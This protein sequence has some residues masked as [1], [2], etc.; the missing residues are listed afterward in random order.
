[1]LSRSKTRSREYRP[2][3][4]PARVAFGSIVFLLSLILCLGLTSSMSPSSTDASWQDATHS[5]GNFNAATVTA[6]VI[7]QCLVRGAL[8]NVRT[9]IVWYIPGEAP[10]SERLAQTEI[11]VE[12]EGALGGLV[13]L[14]LSEDDHDTS[15]GSSRYTTTVP[16][17]LLEG[18]LLGT[19]TIDFANQVEGWTSTSASVRTN[20]GIGGLL[21]NCSVQ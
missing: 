8:V 9:E 7:E 3:N 19:A 11:H 18:L 13:R 1:M 21:G 17:S 2:D 16:A 20:A 14:R 5:S 4:T 12:G 10:S 6:P 15:V